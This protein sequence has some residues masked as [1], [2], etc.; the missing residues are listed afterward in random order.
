MNPTTVIR[1]TLV[2]AVS[3]ALLVACGSS[4]KAAE[5]TQTNPATTTPTASTTVAAPPATTT[6]VTTTTTPAGVDRRTPA[7]KRAA[8]LILRLLEKPKASTLPGPLI[9]STTQATRLSA[10]SRKLH[11]AG[12]VVTTNGGALVGYLVFQSRAAALADLAAFPPNSGPNTI[13]KRNLP[14]F[15]RPSYQLRAN[16]NGYVVR[17]VVF[18]DGPVIVNAWAYG[19]PGK[20]DGQLVKVVSTDARWG[21]AR[22]R[23]ARASSR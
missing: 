11:A 9:G 16:G 17:Y 15:P 5:D 22:L 21:L 13:V 19:K 1:R 23:A 18:V 20:A 3:A 10:G 12:A 4:H 8:N 2:L 14:G 7:E 6:T